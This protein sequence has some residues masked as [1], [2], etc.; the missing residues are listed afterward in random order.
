MDDAPRILFVPPV[1]IIREWQAETRRYVKS[2]S[3]PAL[4]LHLERALRV[5][6]P[7]NHPPD[8]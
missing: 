7:S 1:T 8:A 2:T 4:F 6:M 5:A 3:K